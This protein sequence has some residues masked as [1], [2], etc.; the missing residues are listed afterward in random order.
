[1]P[2]NEEDD[3]TVL[4]EPKLAKLSEAELRGMVDSLEMKLERFEESYLGQ[5]TLE[6]DNIGWKPLGAVQATETGLDLAHIKNQA[7][8]GMAMATINP[9]V[10]RGIA[11]RT[12]YIWGSGV[13][14]TYPEDA[15]YG[16][17]LR[18]V[19]GKTLAQFEIERTLAATGNLFFE[20]S[21]APAISGETGTR[22]R[23]RM[24]P[25]DY[26]TG[27]SANLYDQ[28]VLD[29]ILLTYQSWDKQA[30][31]TP[32]LNSVALAGN[33]TSSQVEEWVP[34]F[35]Q[36]GPMP[37]QIDGIKVS[38]NKRIKHVAVNRM[39]DWW[40]GVPDLYAVTS[41]V[42]AYKK[43]LE[44]CHMLNEAYAQIAFKASSSTR[45][46]GE[47]MASGMA[48][49]PGVD[50]QTGQPLSVG[51]TVAMGAGQD[52]VAVQT[53]RPVDFS[54]GL[55]IAAMVAAG[56]EIP[57]QV[58]TSDASTGGSRSS[59]VALDEATK[60]AMQ[61]RQQMLEDE[62]DDLSEMLGLASFEIEWPRVGEEPLHRTLQALDVAGNTGMLYKAEWRDEILKALGRDSETEEPPSEDELPVTVQVGQG[63][64]AAIEPGSYGEH[65][66][67][68]EPGG[69]A[70][71]ED[72]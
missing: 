22:Q 61:A 30:E 13:K 34:T 51:A 12:S 14:L 64:Q 35:E 58:M 46:G 66:K 26:V 21:T 1:M 29:Y 65:D 11:V 25:L 3:V 16:K 9:L 59:D 36:E 55:P 15:S 50:P 57:L 23:V 10:K 47:R 31:G 39:V 5:L 20:V 70:H 33:A 2:H 54:N 40:W 71:V 41:W 52:L 48:V 37:A 7:E 38:K 67:R 19:L 62:L 6:I 32:N 53:G 72:S 49:N 68:N 18:R 27:G 60:K 43:Y 56:L 8:V 44:Q 28:G 42:R 63:Q 69:Q 45:A 24:V 4:E 17:T